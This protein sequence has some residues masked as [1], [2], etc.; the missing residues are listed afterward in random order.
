MAYTHDGQNGDIEMFSTA[1]LVAWARLL[2][3]QRK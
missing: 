3:E 1:V 2:D